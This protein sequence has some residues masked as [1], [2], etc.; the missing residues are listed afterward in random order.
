METLASAV[1][2]HMVG[3]YLLQNDWMATKK[4]QRS[5][6]CLVHCV[7]WTISVL[8]FS[9]WWRWDV[10]IFLFVC[11]FIQDRSQLI[12][13]WMSIQQ[14]GFMEPPL[15][16]WSIIVVDNVW[17]LVQLWIAWKFLI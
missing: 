15:G 16:P 11:H 14:K 4:K 8:V 5:L 7:L 2:G 17:H 13:K 12:V 1:I 10:A 3:D 9:G 6:P